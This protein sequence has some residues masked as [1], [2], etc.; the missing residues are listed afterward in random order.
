ML[1]YYHV[2]LV[3]LNYSSRLYLVIFCCAESG[4]G[5]STCVPEKY[6]IINNL[7]LTKE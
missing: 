7:A 4:H 6:A 3:V 1:A 2:M 5:E